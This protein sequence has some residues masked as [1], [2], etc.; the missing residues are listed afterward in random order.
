M[1]VFVTVLVFVLVIFVIVSQLSLV[2]HFHQP[3]TTGQL[4][5]DVFGN[6]KVSR[7]E[8]DFDL[9]VTFVYDRTDVTIMLYRVLGGMRRIGFIS[10]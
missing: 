1:A 2:T 8:K 6:R 4:L 3:S 5:M 9:N 7:I 10:N